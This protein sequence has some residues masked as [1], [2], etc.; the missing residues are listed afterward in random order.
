MNPSLITECYVGLG[1]NLD[2]PHEH[3]I[4]ALWDI[5]QI[6]HTDLISFSSLYTSRP[7]GPQDQPPYINAAA[8][9]ETRLDAQSLL[10]ALQ[11]I[12]HAH[13]RVRKKEQW[14]PRTLDLDILIF[15]NQSIDNHTLTVPHPGIARREFVLYP[16]HELNK[17]LMIP[18][19]G[20]IYRIKTRCYRNGLI[21]LQD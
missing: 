5:D 2:N 20:R 18:H 11:A 3:V 10:Q 9:I 17:H 7:M 8:R 19:L 16:L 1:S 13:G 14:G 4:D 12:E 15:G 21:Q 6:E